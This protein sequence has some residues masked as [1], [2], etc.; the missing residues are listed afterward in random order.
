MADGLSAQ[1][2]SAA[3]TEELK[4]ALLLLVATYRFVIDLQ[5]SKIASLPAELHRRKSKPRVLPRRC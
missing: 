1:W 2:L 3:A 5:A 4:P